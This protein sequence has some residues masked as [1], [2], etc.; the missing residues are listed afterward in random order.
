[1]SYFTFSHINHILCQILKKSLCLFPSRNILTAY[2]S[3]KCEILNF[4]KYL[5]E[6][7]FRKKLIL[8]AKRQTCVTN[9]KIGRAEAQGLIEGWGSQEEIK[10]FFMPTVSSYKNHIPFLRTGCFHPCAEPYFYR[11]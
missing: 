2:R 5:F 1:M 7:K 3:C 11:K 4:N 9:Q 10:T 8:Y 6:R